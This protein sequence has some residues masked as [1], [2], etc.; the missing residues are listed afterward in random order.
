[1]LT[2]TY[3]FVALATEQDNA[4]GTLA[5][6]QQYVRDAWDSLQGFDAVEAA[7][8]KLQQFDKYC[9][10]RKI[11]VHLVPVLRRACD[12]AERLIGELQ[13]IADHGFSLLCSVRA[14]LAAKRERPTEL[15]HQLD[16][17]CETGLVLLERE[18][19]ELLPLAKRV[20][21]VEDWFGIAAQLLSSDPQARAHRKPGALRV[22]SSVTHNVNAN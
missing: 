7:L 13:C 17:Y 22:R 1:M 12:E 4:R 5:R 18:E 15:W 19:R 20:L 9:R 2:A 6:L 8:G 21:S 16:Q 10:Q 11:E 14:A 3:S